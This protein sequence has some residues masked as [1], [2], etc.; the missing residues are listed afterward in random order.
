MTYP[1]GREDIPKV[2]NAKKPYIYKYVRKDRE[3]GEDTQREKNMFI[4]NI[5]RSHIPVFVYISFS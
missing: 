3:N 1:I 5:S 4:E 2:L